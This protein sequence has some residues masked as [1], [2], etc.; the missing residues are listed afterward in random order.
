MT[1]KLTIYIGYDEKEKIN[2]DVLVHSINRNQSNPVTIKPLIQSELRKS[3]SYY[4]DSQD[5]C[6]TEFGFTRFL[7]PHLNDYQ[8]WAVFMDCD[9][10]LTRDP[11][12]IMDHTNPEKSALCCQHDYKSSTNIKMDNMKQGSF[13]RKNWSSF[14]LYNC[15]HPDCKRLTPESIANGSPAYLHQF[16]WTTDNKLGIM[17]LEFNWLVGEYD[18]YQKGKELPFNLHYTLGSPA[19][20]DLGFEQYR[21]CDYGDVWNEG[22]E[23][24]E[25][26]QEL[27]KIASLEKQTVQDYVNSQTIFQ[28]RH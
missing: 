6:A 24:M 14:I 17:P 12:E 9:M 2:Y 18:L 25:N 11:W 22:K 7:V 20:A 4:R 13:P 19:F 3:G 23:H 15:E 1:P 27:R 28:F 26:Y 16:K 8:G 10:L 21:N 5:G